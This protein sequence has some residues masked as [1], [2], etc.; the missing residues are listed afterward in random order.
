[1]STSSKTKKSS[2][3]DPSR[4]VARL[5]PAKAITVNEEST[6]LEAARLMKSHR[7]AAVL[8]TNWEGA[9]TGIFSD[10]DS[11]RRVVSKGLDPA[12]VTIGSV[13]TP[14]PS[15]VS[16]EDSA[17]EAMDM[18]LSGKFRHLPVVSSNSGNIVG[19]LNVA[20]CLHDA[21]RR[22]ENMSAS[23]QQE[24]GANNN[25][26]MLRG[27]LEKMLS[28]SLL[29]V[30]SKPGEVMPPLVYGH[31]TVYEATTYMA[32]TRR[33]ALVVS[34]NPEAQDLVGIFTPKDVLLRVIAEDLDVHT[35]IVSDVMTPNPESAAPETSVLDA[36][37]IM[38]DGKFLNLPVV[39]PE[40][41]EIMGVADVLSI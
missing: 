7:S 9:L 15:C 27:M 31:M 37:H 14:N 18:M 2:T 11:A 35:T 38:H 1:M 3:S 21:I 5:R 25:N 24:L 41:G 22:V 12:R 20:K 23:L 40:S 17:V 29:D 26:A 36:F 28:P 4:T 10:T 6:V 34:S 32:E 19:V 39:A 33:P 16:L 8:V 13:M 30:L